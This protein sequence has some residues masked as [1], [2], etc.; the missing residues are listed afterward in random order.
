ML[1]DRDRA[2][3]HEIQNQFLVDDPGFV[4]T[5]DARPP[6]PI[7]ASTPSRPAASPTPTAPTEQRQRPH[8]LFMWT[9]ALLCMLLP[10]AAGPTGGALLLGM[11]AL[12]VLVAVYRTGGTTGTNRGSGP[13]P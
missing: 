7:G 1:S 5:F 8:T 12:A 13:P 10:A 6:R 4:Q 11:S 2:T 3:L 9:A